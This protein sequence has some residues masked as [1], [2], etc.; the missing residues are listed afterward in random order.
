MI[1]KERGYLRLSLSNT[2]GRLV[3]VPGAD[4]V[5][6]VARDRRRMKYQTKPAMIAKP[7]MIQSQ[8]T[9]LPSSAGAGAGGEPGVA[10][11]VAWARASFTAPSVTIVKAWSL[12]SIMF[13][14]RPKGLRINVGHKP[15]FLSLHRELAS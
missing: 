15:A 6:V 11:G 4:E 3:G 10:G 7:M 9:P 1:P 14:F 2:L 8:G 12:L 5:P 13:P